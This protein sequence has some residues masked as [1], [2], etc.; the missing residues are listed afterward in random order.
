MVMTSF[1][2]TNSHTPCFF[3]IFNDSFSVAGLLT[4]LL[5]ASRPSC[6]HGC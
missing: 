1:P 2:C 6:E 3:P 4:L 5:M